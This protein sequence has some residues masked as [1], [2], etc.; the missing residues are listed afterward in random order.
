MILFQGNHRILYG[1]IGFL[2]GEEQ[3][4]FIDQFADTT[5][6]S[7][8]RITV[9][10]LFLDRNTVKLIA[11]S[12]KLRNIIMFYADRKE[13]NDILFCIIGVKN[14]R[15]NLYKTDGI[16]A[17]YIHTNAPHTLSPKSFVILVLSRENYGIAM[18]LIE[19]Y[20]GGNTPQKVA[21]FRLLTES[22]TNATPLNNMFWFIHSFLTIV[23]IVLVNTRKL[24]VS[25]LKH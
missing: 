3:L 5:I 16:F 6:L 7:I 2:S 21:G 12:S 20:N 18:A 11:K 17:D 9:N 14:C 15:D 13:I 25:S 1:V 4:N 23:I 22:T 19:I 10:N 8:D 24:L